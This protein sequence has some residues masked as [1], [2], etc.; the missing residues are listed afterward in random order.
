MH[1]KAA[2]WFKQQRYL[3]E[4]IY[5]AQQ[6]E[7]QQLILSLLNSVCRELIL[8]G[9]HYTFL[10]LVKQIPD[11]VLVQNPNLL[12]DIIWTLVLTHQ[13]TLANHYLQL[14]HSVDQ[15]ETLLQHEDQLGLAPHCCF[16]RQ[17]RCGLSLSA[18]KLSTTA[19]YRLFCPC[20][21]DW[22]WGFTS[23]LFGANE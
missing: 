12:Y 18:T 1:S 6:A 17:V 23:H 11:S 19:K 4:A 7:D 2:E 9:R 10:E 20:S 21:T 3:M 5:H 16:R 14:W 22:D 13:V 8:E 15:H